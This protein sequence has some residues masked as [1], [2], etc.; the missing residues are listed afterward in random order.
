MDT[1][2]DFEYESVVSDSEI[3]SGLFDS[4]SR[5]RSAASKAHRRVKSS[6]GSIQ[7][8]PASRP[9]Y[10]RRATT[11]SIPSLALS[12]PN[13]ERFQLEFERERQNDP[14]FGS[15]QQSQSGLKS[16]MYNESASDFS[17]KLRGD[18][19]VSEKWSAVGHQQDAASKP[20]D[21]AKSGGGV[22]VAIH[23]D[24]S[25]PADDTTF[26]IPP[27]NESTDVTLS[28]LI[29][30][31][32]IDDQPKLPTIQGHH[33]CEETTAQE[34]IGL[35]ERNSSEQQQ[36]QHQQPSR[37]LEPQSILSAPTKEVTANS[38]HDPLVTP[39]ISRT[40]SDKTGDNAV[41]AEARVL[42][43]ALRGSRST[44]PVGGGVHFDDA[45]Q[46]SPRKVSFAG[47]QAL[48]SPELSAIDEKGAESAKEP[49]M[50]VPSTQAD[51][52]P[53]SESL[54]FNIVS[55]TP[56]PQFDEIEPGNAY[57]HTEP[58]SQSGQVD[59][60][61]LGI[62]GM[63]AVGVGMAGGMFRKF[64]GWSRNRLSS[65]SATPPPNSLFVGAVED[66]EEGVG[67]EEP[68]AATTA[69]ELPTGY[70]QDI[71]MGSLSSSQ[72]ASTVSPVKTEPMRS[73]MLTSATT[74]VSSSHDKS[75]SYTTP[76]PQP[77]SARRASQTPSRSVNPLTRHLAIKAIQ[78]APPVRYSMLDHSEV[79]DSN[80]SPTS[81]GQ[82]DNTKPLIDNILDSSG[83]AALD[84]SVLL[85]LAEL[86][87]QFDGFASQLKHDASAVHADVRESEEAWYAMQHELQGLRSQLLNAETARDFLQQQ[88]ADMD[89]ERVEWEQERQQMADD[90][91]ELQASVDRWR[92]RIGDLESE[93][94]GAWN[95]GSQTREQLLQTIVQLEEDLR[96]TNERHHEKYETWG[97]ERQELLQHI[98]DLMA[99]Y[100]RVDAENRQIQA[101]YHDKLVELE[102]ERVLSANLQSDLDG[103]AELEAQAAELSNSN[104][105]LKEALE[106]LTERNREI[107]QTRDE[108]HLFATA[109]GETMMQTS[110][111]ATEKAITT[112]EQ[113]QHPTTETETMAKIR[114]E[115][116]DELERVSHDYQLLLETMENLSESKKRY[117]SDNAEL[118]T[119]AES[120]RDEIEELKR[121][122]EQR[123]QSNES[124]TE[125]VRLKENEQ[126][127]QRELD[128]CER[129]KQGLIERTQVLSEKNDELAQRT[130]RLE[131][132]LADMQLHSDRIEE[133]NLKNT[134]LQ[135]TIVD[136]EKELVG[137]H[138]DNDE[139]RQSMAVK[140]VQLD[141]AQMELGRIKG[142][143]NLQHEAVKAAQAKVAALQ[144]QVA[145]GRMRPVPGT[146]SASTGGSP[147][148]EHGAQTETREFELRQSKRSMEANIASLEASIAQAMQRRERLEKEKRLLADGLR[149]LL[150]N[151]A[152]LRMELTAILLRRAGKLRD[153]QM[154]QR[155]ESQSTD[156]AGTSMVSGMLNNVPSA[157]QL[158]DGNSRF[159][160]SLDKHLDEVANIIE[161]DE[162]SHQPASAPTGRARKRMLT[163]IKEETVAQDAYTHD[164][165]IQCDISNA[166]EQCRA[167]RAALASAKQERD[168][169]RASHEEASESVARLSGQI[170][171]LSE[172][173]ER[174]KANRITTTRIALRVHRQLAVLARALSRL[175]HQEPAAATDS[176]FDA[177]EGEDALVLA[178]EDEMFNA[179]LDRPLDAADCALLGLAH[180][181][182]T[183]TQVADVSD[184]LDRNGD[185][186]SNDEA[187]EEIAASIQRAYKDLKR[188][189]WDLRRVRNDRARLMRRLAKADSSRLPSYKLSTQWGRNMRS[190]SY[191][192][193]Q[194]APVADGADAAESLLDDS[195]PP[196]SLFLADESA[197]MAELAA[198][199][200]G[201]QNEN[202]D[203]KTSALDIS[204]IGDPS[205]AAA[206]IT[207]LTV[208][209]RIR[210]R[211]LRVVEAE[212]QRIEGYNREL[213]QLA[214]RA[215][216]DRI[217]AQQESSAAVRRHSVRSASRITTP[218]R[219]TDWDDI[220][221]IEHELKRC[222]AKNRT[223]FE[224]VD[225]LCRVLG[226]HT[227][228]QALAD[229]ETLQHDSQD[230]VKSPVLC[231]NVYRTLLIDMATMLDARGDL[232][233]HKSI[234]DN[235]RSMAA[236]VRRRLDS[237]DQDLNRIQSEL[238]VSRLAVEAEVPAAEQRL[239]VAERRATELETQVTDAH[240]QLTTQQANIRSLNA[241][242]SR[243]R[244]QCVAAEADVQEARLERDGWHQQ[245]LACEQ[246]LSY[247][248]SE[249]DR[250]SRSLEEMAQLH[251]RSMQQQQQPHVNGTDQNGTANWDYLNKEWV[252]ATRK[253]A[254]ESWRGKEI[255]L[256][257]THKAQI[258][259]LTCAVQ[260]WG[261]I[262]RAVATEPGVSDPDSLPVTSKGR[263][264]RQAVDELDTEVDRAVEKTNDIQKKLS[265]ATSTDSAPSRATLASSLNR[266]VQSIN[267][268]F[269]ASW[270][271]NVRQ[272]IVAL[273]TDRVE[274]P[275][276]ANGKSSRG[277]PS[278]SASSS[279]SSSFPRITDE[280]KALIREHYGHREANIK[281]RM[282]DQLLA[283]RNE[284]K[285][286]EEA[287]IA[288]HK[289][290]KQAL[291]AES[292]YLRGRMNIE[293][294]KLKFVYYQKKCLLQ[295]L[296]GQVGV[297]CKI[298]EM[299]R[300]KADPKTRARELVKAR[301]RLVLLAVR[302]KNRLVEMAHMASEVNAIKTKALSRM[303]LRG[304]Q[305]HQLLPTENPKLQNQSS[306]RSPT[307]PL[308]TAQE[309][310][311]RTRA[312]KF[313][314]NLRF[315]PHQLIGL[316][317]VPIT[318]S[319]LRNHASDIGGS[320][321]GSSF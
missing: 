312:I 4:S 120:A 278:N 7:S 155:T 33:S 37:H 179:T 112:D 30:E 145:P 129:E 142:E 147:H 296:G 257:Q 305:Q 176:Q 131:T 294:N 162:P 19:V 46:A 136:M 220:D 35:S 91:S 118:T 205:I 317:S 64:A 65:R 281:Q 157:S 261:S 247:Q 24:S 291:I 250:L 71:T 168:Q 139:L 319:R 96:L 13:S 243:L 252:A 226:R 23:K 242:I 283:E 50:Y 161:D 53:Q 268:H 228:D 159:L 273:T 73:Q 95:E 90:K 27:F 236:A 272:L 309:N 77:A 67:K 204:V 72:S 26:E 29:R 78:S 237:K 87:R 230:D 8:T 207:R 191:A 303:S 6:Q 116:R 25:A 169:F 141:D 240:E 114:Q 315:Q 212:L 103:K 42:R 51:A 148:L 244:Q 52:L 117:K 56:H 202:A 84:D 313:Y 282:R 229:S 180:I 222:A 194:D 225:Q 256:C 188:V 316:K 36:N 15:S 183:D 215:I 287:A 171:E 9:A 320:S 209:L 105:L 45:V 308:D 70:K 241:S 262:L 196:A 79:S 187:L 16:A 163:P 253:E 39:K 197:V 292:C 126:E 307:P 300:Q 249:N 1:S 111:N 153:L 59:G 184:I 135:K 192:E 32:S 245:F 146:P 110:P 185:E 115:H 210:D 174:A 284:C 156:E 297:F 286:R 238:D 132:E 101:N 234:R 213:T 201:S 178:E 271:G 140:E 11:D 122:L 143:C 264:L 144:S 138:Q 28:R 54:N 128:S 82:K 172:H 299:A 227:I 211:R 38:P 130:A 246:T 269:T 75:S 221:A 166:E 182:D 277:S 154:L 113:Q 239:R 295:L 306:Y 106:D 12:T 167:L 20:D 265:S 275:P 44:P 175:T 17:A 198:A 123:Q 219:G 92:Q 293:A 55:A 160:N 98:D 47:T 48:S 267:E 255:E 43:S 288:K 68:I 150:L 232:D 214:D 199:K 97:G 203:A 310:D 63:S 190:R 3:Y 49:E 200:R 86:Q 165:A 151:N 80:A 31:S 88:M 251:E 258:E 60:T 58:Q 22:S 218:G 14:H 158:L 266:I 260:T 233:E 89:Q 76:R 21:L 195:D 121:Q 107:K 94:T 102:D 280:Q 173:H 134:Y 235:F 2:S 206:E 302:M 152:T 109:V 318:P 311:D 223:Y 217:R 254:V 208:E 177:D 83:H 85:S 149:D 170:E 99:E 81:R 119:M 314:N 61:R 289:R 186:P 34:T 66:S 279:N 57:Q 10:E 285:A 93:R 164:T 274:Q 231:E 133:L 40:L 181:S 193:G 69:G 127:L 137:K 298:D 5:D 125:L 216:A 189:R 104:Q 301:W 224:S 41:P 74:P 290:E 259:I 62:G 263:A 321:T 100:D 276:S 124:S 18:V 270:C 248:I 304:G 108:S